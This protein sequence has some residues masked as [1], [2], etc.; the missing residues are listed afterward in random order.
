MNISVKIED[1][2]SDD[3]RALLASVTGQQMADINEVGAK[4]AVESAEKYH[5]DFD[6][7]GKWSRSTLSRVTAGSKFGSDITNAW[8]FRSATA[9]G[10]EIGNN[11]QIFAHKVNGGTIRPK[12]A[13]ALTIPMIDEARG[14]SAAAYEIATGR[15][16]FT[17]PGRNVL[18]EQTATASESVR[19][20]TYG[21]M[22]NGRRVQVSARGGIRGVYALVK[23]VTQGP[24]PGAMPDEDSLAEGFFEGWKGGLYAHIELLK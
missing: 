4:G 12:R 8:S 7:A 11:S 16:L 14:V 19:N 6:K 3:L 22:K 5:G 20:R 23:S 9:D 2:L 18:F 17:I 13:K 1:Q 10:A 15:R 24:W 21:R